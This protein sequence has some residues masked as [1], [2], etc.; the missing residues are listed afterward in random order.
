MEIEKKY[1]KKLSN[2]KWKV[3]IQLFMKKDT[4]QRLYLK[5]GITEFLD[6]DARMFFNNLKEDDSFAKHFDTK[7]MWSEIFPNKVEAEKFEEG[8]LEYFGEQVDMGFKTGGY[9]EVREYNHDKW[10]VKSKELYDR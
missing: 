4:K 9:S 2:G 1:Y 6:G 10:I 8:L 5:P 3:Y 7:V